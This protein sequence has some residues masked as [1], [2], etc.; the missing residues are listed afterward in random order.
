MIRGSIVALITPMH[1]NGEVDYQTLEKLVE[2]HVQAGTDGIVAVGT[3]GESA[4]LP[5]DEHVKVVETVVKT[6]NN[7]VKV[8][9]GNGANSTS[10]AVELTLRMSQLSGIDAFLCVTPYYNK[11]SQRGLIKHFEAI[12]NSSHIPQI[13]YNV[14]GRT[15]VDM[16]PPAVAEL[17]QHD[18]II[19]IKEATGSIDRLHEIKA[20]VS[21]D[22][23]LLS[24]D[25][26]T[27][28]AFLQAGGH[29]VIS[30][31]ANVAPSEVSNICELIKQDKY[32]EAK[33]IDEKILILHQKLFVESNPVPV[34]WALFRMGLIPE[35]IFR[36]PLLE[37]EPNSK[38]VIEQALQQSGFIHA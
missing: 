16:L 4:T 10:E 38:L 29:G 19:G 31:T 7:R 22:F 6:A 20:L 37:P 1:K 14:P 11:P 12:A 28:L 36:L 18:K 34:K 15:A 26:E 30:V 27:S 13:L 9:A 25:D 5:V 35:C 21:D 32:D 23:S 17:S 24:G 8:I 2:F 3:T 33:V